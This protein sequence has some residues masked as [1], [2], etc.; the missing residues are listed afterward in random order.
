MAKCLYV[1]KD[2][3]LCP[4]NPPGSLG[5]LAPHSTH[6]K[7]PML[8]SLMSTSQEPGLRIPNSLPHFKRGTNHRPQT[9]PSGQSDLLTN[10]WE[11][12]PRKE[13]VP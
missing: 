6:S 2:Q 4:S 9:L 1:A 7:D 11:G 13:I 3:K 10:E 12:G 8:L 5:Q